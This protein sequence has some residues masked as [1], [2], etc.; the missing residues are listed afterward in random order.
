MGVCPRVVS[1]CH[2]RK[3]HSQTYSPLLPNRVRTFV[4]EM[5]V[6]G[7]SAK[8]TAVGGLNAITSR[9]MLLDS[10]ADGS[11]AFDRR[12]LEAVPYHMQG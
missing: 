11:G 10:L 9:R 2:T 1:T 3:R 5:R 8:S 12:C 7:C 6:Y 4:F